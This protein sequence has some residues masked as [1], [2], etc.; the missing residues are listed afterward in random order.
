M[1]LFVVALILQP[2]IGFCQLE[3]NNWYFGDSASVTFSSGVPQYT[4]NGKLSSYESGSS[5]SDSSG[6]LLFYSSGYEIWNRDHEIMT[7]G[8][9]LNLGGITS[10]TQGVLILN[11]PG[12]FNR[13]YLM[14]LYAKSAVQY[15]TYS[16]IDMSLDNGNGA[17]LIR[18]DTLIVQV[19]NG[20]PYLNEK[21]TAVKHAN[22]KDW[23]ILLHK[24]ETDEF[25]LYLLD[26]DGLHGPNIQAIGQ[27]HPEGDIGEMVFDQSGT[28][29]A[30]SW[31]LGKIDYFKFDRCN[32]ILSNYI[33]VF[34]TIVSNNSGSHYFYGCEFSPNGKMIYM[35]TFTRVYQFEIDTVNNQFTKHVIWQSPDTILCLGQLQIGP[36]DRI[37]TPGNHATIWPP[38]EYD[39]TNMYLHTILEPDSS[40]S[41]CNFQ[42][43]NVYLGGKRS[44]LNLPN[45]PNYDLGALPSYEVIAGEDTIIF[46][47]DSV[48]LGSAQVNGIVYTWQPNDGSLSATDI[49]QPTATPTQTTQYILTV[50]DT[51]GN[52]SCAVRNDTVMVTVNWHDGVGG[53]A[54][55]GGITIYPNPADE[56]CVV[57]CELC[58]KENCNLK[59]FDVMGKEIYRSIISTSEFKLETSNFANGIYFVRIDGVEG[60]M[61]TGRFVVAR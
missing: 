51:S 16:L 58:E 46:L 30:A 36:D 49:A 10:Y 61:K 33:N 7:G 21:M 47:G 14:T 26:A 4:L 53:V 2:V 6:N 24:G 22:A 60:R 13:Y 11:E 41:A 18:N 56:L 20:E 23:W 28:Q 43:Y 17:V 29:L 54:E 15:F 25:L 12:S 59:V 35:T 31:V 1:R 50:N 9:Y 8:E 40:G 52:Y 48:E 5:I 39:S 32:G 55:E 57:N 27:D 19:M 44:T 37:Y 38:Q 34:D 45:L 3:S 42:L